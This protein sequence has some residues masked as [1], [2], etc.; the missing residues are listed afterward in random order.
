MNIIFTIVHAYSSYVVKVCLQKHFTS[1]KIFFITP[2]L[3]C[4]VYWEKKHC[5]NIYMS[6][7]L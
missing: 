4:L 7:I 5:Y 6:I 3:Y 2:K 1:V